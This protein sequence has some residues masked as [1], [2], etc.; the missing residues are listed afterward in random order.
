MR[1]CVSV[2]WSTT[3]PRVH[4]SWYFCEGN[5][6]LVDL[7]VGFHGPGPSQHR[8]PPLNED[9]FMVLFMSS[10]SVFRPP[11][12]SQANQLSLPTINLPSFLYPFQLHVPNQSCN[13][14][15]LWEPRKALGG[16]GVPGPPPIRR[17][18]PF[19]SNPDNPP[20]GGGGVVSPGLPRLNPRGSSKEAPAGRSSQTPCCTAPMA[21]CP[22]PE[23][24]PMGRRPEGSRKSDSGDSPPRGV[25]HSGEGSHYIFPPAAPSSHFDPFNRLMARI[26][27]LRPDQLP[28]PRGRVN[29]P[30][31]KGAPFF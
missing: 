15:V 14:R 8:P 12:M 13:P 22:L 30:Q 23:A 21:V 25:D 28:L 20:F 31:I 10:N 2:W 7:Q 1:F 24:S 4:L 19:V 9:D 17:G 26:R 29:T 3:T 5:I 18:V 6:L 27:H 16:G 11:V